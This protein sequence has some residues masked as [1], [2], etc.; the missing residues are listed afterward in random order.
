MRPAPFRAHS[1]S[2][3]IPP[4][5]SRSVP[6]QHYARLGKQRQARAY[7]G[8]IYINLTP[9]ARTGHSHTASVYTSKAVERTLTL[10]LFSS[11]SLS[12][13]PCPAVAIAGIVSAAE[14]DTDKNDR[15]RRLSR[16]SFSSNARAPGV[17]IGRLVGSYLFSLVCVGVQSRE[18]RSIEPNSQTGDSFVR[19]DTPDSK[20]P[21][22]TT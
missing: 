18:G 20:F 11:R 9:H 6:R 7:E 16:R 22:G 15:S 10:P 17:I 4:P 13:S 1:L 2:R 8:R 12:L 5:A 21:L 19:K 14:S 3:S